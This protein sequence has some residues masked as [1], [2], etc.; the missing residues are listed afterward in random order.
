MPCW[1]RLLE[2]RLNPLRGR[3]C[4]WSVDSESFRELTESRGTNEDRLRNSPREM[5]AVPD[6]HNK[7]IIAST[8]RWVPLE[9][10]YWEGCLNESDAAQREKYRWT[11]IVDP[12]LRKATARQVA[13]GTACKLAFS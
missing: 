10:V 2:F 13:D 6:S 9:L 12:P 5:R 8:R 11:A 3:K 4:A 7:G 1:Q